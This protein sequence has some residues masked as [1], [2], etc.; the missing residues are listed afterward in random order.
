M[1]GISFNVTLSKEQIEEIASLTTD[2]V[3]Q[4]NVYKYANEE[5]VKQEIE[6]LERK[7]NQLNQMIVEREIHIERW[8][9]LSRLW[10]KRCD[11]YKEK[12]G[13]LE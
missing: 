11:Q 3:R 12:F 13:E 6:D 9:D 7:V 2:K 10:K 8:K 5:W 4:A 1:K